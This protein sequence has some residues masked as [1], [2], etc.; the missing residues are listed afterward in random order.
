MTIW[1]LEWLRLVRTHR[2]TVLLGVFAFLGFT[3][4]LTA[5]Y[6]GE[7]LKALGTG[8]IEVN[9]PPPRPVD[10]IAE[11]AGNV[12]QIGLLVVVL[13]AASALA[14]DGRR[15]MALFLRTRLPVRAIVFPAYAMNVGAAVLGCAVGSAT[16]WY[17]TALLLGPLPAGRMLLGVGLT[18]V[19]LAFAIAVTALTASLTRST[20]AAAGSALALLLAM[21][22]AGSVPA[23]A[24]F[25]PTSLAGA[26][27]G[28]AGDTAVSSFV[29]AAA[30]A[31]AAGVAC[32][33]GAIAISTRHEI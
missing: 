2:L 20:I 7:I 11:Y 26:M 27:T 17:E 21:A 13:I 4:P 29:P 15:E 16:A 10:G 12:S 28:L 22:I 33:A 8:G 5:R 32:V 3:G 18:A 23:V 31:V 6:L 9:F 14:F 30:I 24:R 25:L 1:R 19:F